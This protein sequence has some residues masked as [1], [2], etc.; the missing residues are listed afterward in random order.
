MKNAVIT[1]ATGVLGTA[2]VK[3]L[4]SENIETFVICHPNSRRNDTILKSPYVHKIFCDLSEIKTIPSKIQLS[5]D[6]F[7][8]F[9]WLG[10]QNNAN[11]MNMYLQNENVKYALDAVYVAKALN[12]QVFIGAGSQAEYGRVEGIISP[13]HIEKPISGYGMAKL[14]AGQMTQAL[15]KSF[16][17]RHIWPRVVSVY[18]ENDAPKTLISMIIRKLLLKETPSLTAGEQLWD[19]LYSED[20]A[21][22]FYA[23]ACHGRDGAKYVLGSGKT[24]PLREFMIETRDAIDP[25]LPLGIGEIPYYPDQAMHLEADISSLTKD[26]GWKPKITFEKG[27]C[28]VIEKMKDSILGGANVFVIFVIT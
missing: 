19:Y 14:C 26:T 3:K 12:C 27:I 16:G 6:A 24:K 9:A 15:C 11:R 23:M 2:L 18:G 13:D 8:H 25:N 22:A 10:T 28:H 20:A 7:F 17:I 5:I 4:A 1:G 21:D